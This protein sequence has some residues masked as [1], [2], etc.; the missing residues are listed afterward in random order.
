MW[1]QE[2][3]FSTTPSIHWDHCIP[4]LSIPS[5]NRLHPTTVQ[6][7]PSILRTAWKSRWR[8]PGWLG[9]GADAVGRSRPLPVFPESAAGQTHLCWTSQQSSLWQGR[10]AW[11]GRLQPRRAAAPSRSPGWLL[12]P[13]LAPNF[14]KPALAAALPR[15]T[16]LPGVAVPTSYR[17]GPVRAHPGP[18]RA[19]PGPVCAHLVPTRASPFPSQADPCPPRTDSC[20]SRAGPC[21][22]RAGPRLGTAGSSGCG[23][24]GSGRRQNTS[25]RAAAACA[26]LK[27]LRASASPKENQD[28]ERLFRF[29][30]SLRA[31]CLSP[32]SKETFQPNPSHMQEVSSWKS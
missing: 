32:S 22:S 19:E 3:S 5:Q 18:V 30:R 17:P 25:W 9:P 12:R 4:L 24:E 1:C 28:G 10:S 26:S 31:K 8:L 6:E 11:T 27:P 15:S 16:H 14:Q 13:R 29:F 7:H 23:S 21:P 20:P 2:S